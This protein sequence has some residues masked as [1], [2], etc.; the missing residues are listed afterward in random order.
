MHSYNKMKAKAEKLTEDLR[1]NESS[2]TLVSPKK[3]KV[4]RHISLMS[5]LEDLDKE[6]TEEAKEETK[7]ESKHETFSFHTPLKAILSLVPNVSVVHVTGK[8]LRELNKRKDPLEEYFTLVRN[9]L[10]NTSC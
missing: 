7:H 6:L 10:D 1:I 5:E 3:Q 8:K 4:R 2:P 9:I